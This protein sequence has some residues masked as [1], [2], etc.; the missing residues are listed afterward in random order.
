MAKQMMK[1]IVGDPG[2]LKLPDSQVQSMF[3]GVLDQQMQ[4]AIATHDHAAIKRIYDAFAEKSLKFA[5]GDSA[6][7]G[8][9]AQSQPHL[10]SVMMPESVYARWSQSEPDSPIPHLLYAST[11]LSQAAEYHRAAIKV[12]SAKRDQP[13]DLAEIEAARDYLLR[14]KKVAAKSAYWYNLMVEIAILRAGGEDE[15]YRLVTE[16]IEAFPDNVQLVVLASTY[17]LPKWYGN[18]QALERYATWV[19][20]LPALKD[21]RDVY[22]QIYANAMRNQYGLTLFKFATKNWDRMRPSLR[23]LAEAYPDE[24][25]VNY[26]AALA[27]LGGDRALTRELMEKENVKSYQA[28]WMDADAYSTCALWAG[29]G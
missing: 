23:Q 9:L 28:Y 10:L 4:L 15:I 5:D 21:R 14:H 8:Y 12:P 17:H 11:R 2:V 7:V 1:D 13:I 22:A 18:A 26:A 24:R 3:R 29:G 6:P 25:N 16:G 20:E 19:S 27:C